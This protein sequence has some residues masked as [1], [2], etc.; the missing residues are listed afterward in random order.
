MSKKKRTEQGQISETKRENSASD[1]SYET[2]N[3][4]VV[5][6]EQPG[7]VF[8][9]YIDEAQA[10]YA[11]FNGLRKKTRKAEWQSVA[12]MYRL[13]LQPNAVP[14]LIA[15]M[16]QFSMV[17][18]KDNDRFSL[19][20]RVSQ[21]DFTGATSKDA[22]LYA[23]ALRGLELLSVLPDE[24]FDKL[25]E[26]GGVRKCADYAAAMNRDANPP[27]NPEDVDVDNYLDVDATPDDDNDDDTGGS[28]E[29]SDNRSSISECR[30]GAPTPS[31]SLD[32]SLLVEMHPPSRSR[33]Q[34]S[35][36]RHMLLRLDRRLSNC[37]TKISKFCD[38]LSPAPDI[39]LMVVKRHDA[40]TE[41]M[42]EI[43]ADHLPHRLLRRL[44]EYIDAAQPVSADEL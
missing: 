19:A 35:L 9:D 40:D 41:V 3:R 16:K 30:S 37:P 8:R 13:A 39:V 43:V 26:M 21:K 20:A 1:G 11:E 24:A 38:D 14:E 34:R 17:L 44:L 7:K 36:D 29:T 15:W 31:P 2:Y 33:L 42:A 6:A 4:P 5:N 32:E 28:S 10:D 23:R 12:S 22:S 27:E 25:A 18:R